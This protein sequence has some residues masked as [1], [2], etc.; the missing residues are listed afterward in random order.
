MFPVGCVGGEPQARGRGIAEWDGGDG[1]SFRG[2]AGAEFEVNSAAARERRRKFQTYVRK[3]QIES[4][5]K[6]TILCDHK[7]YS[8]QVHIKARSWNPEAGILCA[9]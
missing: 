3:D 1:S 9:K 7:I 4:G 6:A 2:H 8:L 5:E